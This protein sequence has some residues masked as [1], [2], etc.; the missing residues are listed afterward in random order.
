MTGSI[1][2]RLAAALGT[3]ALAAG[4]AVIAAP[5]AH[6]DGPGCA[7]YLAGGNPA[8]ST[9]GTDVACGV[10]A[11]GL[12]NP[13]VGKVLCETLMSKVDQVGP[14]RTATACKQAAG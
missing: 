11:L 4:G 5:A 8:R 2:T 10:G 1:R 13:A 9:L 12:P 7:N 3:L 6:A 14:A